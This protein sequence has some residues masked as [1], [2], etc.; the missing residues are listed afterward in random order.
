MAD[1]LAPQKDELSFLVFRAS[2][3]QARTL[4]TFWKVEEALIWECLLSLLGMLFMGENIVELL[5]C[6]T[7]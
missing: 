4:T 3:V 7:P 6:L 2:S 5:M 1:F